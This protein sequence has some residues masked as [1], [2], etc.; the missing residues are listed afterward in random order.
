MLSYVLRVLLRKYFYLEGP[1]TKTRDGVFGCDCDFLCHIDVPATGAIETFNNLRTSIRK[2]LY[3]K[4]DRKMV[5]FQVE[6]SL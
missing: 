4:R 6:A 5:K 1:P 2:R 3:T